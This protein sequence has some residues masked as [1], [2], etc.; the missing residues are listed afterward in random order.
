MTEGDH[1]VIELKTKFADFVERYERDQKDGRTWRDD[2]TA[3]LK[4]HCDFIREVSPIYRRL[5]YILTGIGITAG[6]AALLA[7]FKHIVWK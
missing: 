4:V 6:G 5:C 7:L 2:T 3:R 1:A